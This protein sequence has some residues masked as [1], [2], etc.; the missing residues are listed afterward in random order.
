[1][2]AHADDLVAVLDHLGVHRAV[3]AGHSMGAY[4][5]TTAAANHRDRWSHVVLVDGGVALPLPPAVDPDAMLAGVLGPALT[6]LDMTFADRDAYHAFWRQHPALAEPGAWNEDTEAWLD[7]DLVATEGGLR[8]SAAIDAVR[9]DGRE[10]LVDRDVRHAFHEL[11]QPTV[12]LRAPRGLLNQVPPLL[13]DE[14]IDP[15]RSR[16]PIRLEMLVE[17]TNHYSI[18]LAARGARVVARH[19]EAAF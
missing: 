5:A 16:W 2:R 15:L 19:I 10:L 17:D 4:V 1:M 14:L 18:V 8:S 7:H 13:P 11:T 6:R 9:F 12:L 3:L